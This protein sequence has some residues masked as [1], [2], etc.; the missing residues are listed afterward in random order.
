MVQEF[1]SFV[2]PAFRFNKKNLSEH[3]KGFL[4]TLQSV[5]NFRDK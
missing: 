4:F 5:P 3:Q 1:S 2:V